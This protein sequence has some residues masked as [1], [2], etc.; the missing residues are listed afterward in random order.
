[1]KCLSG[2][3]HNGKHWV[4]DKIVIELVVFGSY[5]LLFEWKL[6]PHPRWTKR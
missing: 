6:Q 3:S 5:F 1:M 4:I 2:I